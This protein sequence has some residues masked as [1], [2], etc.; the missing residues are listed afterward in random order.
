MGGRLYNPLLGVAGGK[1]GSEEK[2][3]FFTAL[4]L[5]VSLAHGQRHVAPRQELTKR[6]D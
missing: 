5:S 4:P 1:E 2:P 3:P 6:K